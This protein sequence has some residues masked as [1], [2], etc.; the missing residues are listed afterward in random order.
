MLATGFINISAC[1]GRVMTCEGVGDAL[2]DSPGAVQGIAVR[3][4]WPEGVGVI[5]IDGIRATRGFPTAEHLIAPEPMSG[6]H[7]HNLTSPQDPRGHV[8]AA[9]EP[10]ICYGADGDGPG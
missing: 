5:I 2:G 10:A 6:G 7:A 9:I 1:P 4:N 3:L 8:A